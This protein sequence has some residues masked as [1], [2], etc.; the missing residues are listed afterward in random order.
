MSSMAESQLS[1][2]PAQARAHAG[3]GNL[4]TLDDFAAR[5]A[6]AAYNIKPPLRL[7]S[8]E[9]PVHHP[10]DDQ[11]LKP[12]ATNNNAAS[13]RPS[14]PAQAPT[15]TRPRE[16]RRTPSDEPS[17]REP[18]RSPVAEPAQNPVRKVFRPPAVTK[19]STTSIRRHAVP[20]LIPPPPDPIPPRDPSP[21]LQI[22]RT[23]SASTA[24]S[25]PYTNE[26]PPT[27]TTT[28]SASRSRRRVSSPLPTPNSS[29]DSIPA[30]VRQ[31][32][33][34]KSAMKAGTQT[35]PKVE[36]PQEPVKSPIPLSAATPTAATPAPGR[37]W[38]SRRSGAP[39][40]LT[41]FAP[42]SYTPAAAT[43]SSTSTTQNGPY[44]FNRIVTPQP[45]EM[46]PRSREAPLPS[47]SSSPWSAYYPSYVTL[48]A[49][50]TRLAKAQ[51][52]YEQEREADFVPS[53]LGPP[54]MP[55]TAVNIPVSKKNSPFAFLSRHRRHDRTL[56][57]A[58]M[59]A[60]G[61]Q[62][63]SSSFF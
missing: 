4:A 36:I 22:Q 63:S 34:R 6:G 9:V 28:N 52:D 15:S 43:S 44:A 23:E 5:L 57:D 48:T 53:D 56:S 30:P 54:P 2:I 33:P 61:S 58:S 32:A 1:P 47:S 49:R 46:K 14:A 21:P 45:Q 8:P 7:P 38:R 50:E 41:A 19:D 59:D 39:A 10:R 55:F 12:V 20:V 24:R 25:V 27:T 17:L 29:T 51:Q 26:T 42:A 16:H 31:P 60:M 3:G 11:P 62:A 18:A 37:V 40:A 13:G 35:Q